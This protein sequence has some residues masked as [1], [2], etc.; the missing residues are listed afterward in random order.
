MINIYGLIGSHQ[1]N[2]TSYLII[3]KLLNQIQ[4]V[5]MLH[6]IDVKYTL[7]YIS[8][9]H[10]KECRGCCNCFRTGCCVMRDDIDIIKNNILNCDIF[11]VISPVY[12]NHITGSLKNVFDRLAYLTHLMPFIGKRG[13]VLANSSL[14]G[15][16]ETINYLK[17]I[18][19]HL[20][21][22]VDYEY[23]YLGDKFYDSKVAFNVHELNDYA[24]KFKHSNLELDETVKKVFDAYYMLYSK[25]AQSSSK[26]KYCNETIYW[27]KNYLGKTISDIYKENIIK[28]RGD[29]KIESKK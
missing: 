21:I 5:F 9:L 27:K 4:K 22:S 2:G 14:S 26:V 23:K 8:D 7:N 28:M 17:L 20:G 12:I 13:I 19:N 6:N 29:Y 10:I 24:L 11:I 3:K 16:E 15:T 1:R 18:L 25:I